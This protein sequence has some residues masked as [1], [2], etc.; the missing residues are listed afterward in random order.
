MS[1]AA[2]APEADVGKSSSARMGGA[3]RVSNPGD[4]HE[5]EA[6]RVADTVMRGGQ[7]PEWSLAAKGFDGIQRKPAESH[8]DPVAQVEHALAA[9]AEGRAAIAKVTAGAASGLTVTGA[10]AADVV[11]ALATGRKGTGGASIALDGIH[12]G[13]SVKVTRGGG[14]GGAEVALNYA[15]QTEGKQAAPEKKAAPKLLDKPEV[16][17]APHDGRGV[18]A[19]KQSG[20]REG[21]EKEELTVHRKAERAEA[22]YTGSAEVDSVLRSPGREMEP[23]TRREMESRIGFDFGRVR[24]HT[25]AR[26]GESAQGLSARAYTVGSDVVFA[27]GKYA[28]QTNEGRHLLAHELTHVVQQTSG[29]ERGRAAGLNVAKPAARIVQR[30][31]WSDVKDWVGDKIDSI[32]N[33]LLSH[34]KDIPGYD[35]FCTL[36]GRDLATGETVERTPEKLISEFLKFFGFDSLYEKLKSASEA[37]KLAFDWLMERVRARHL[38]LEDFEDLLKRAWDAVELTDLS[39]TWERLKAIFAEP[40]NNIKE[41]VKEIASKVLELIAEAVFNRFPAGRKIWQI[42]K[43]AAQAIG[44]IATSPRRFGET[45]LEA[46]K[47]GFQ[48]FDDHLGE[49]LKEGLLQFVFD[50]VGLPDLKA[51]KSFDLSSMFN[52]A[53][54]VLGLTYARRRKQ[55]VEKLE[56][57][58]GEVVV[59]YAEK[60]VEIVQQVRK[61]GFGAIWEMIKDKLASIP[62]TIFNAVKGWAIT[63][64]VKVGLAKIAALTNPVGEIIE[65]IEDIVETVKF[66]IEKASQLIDLFEAMVDMFSDLA[67]GN[68]ESAAV[69]VEGVIKK[70]IPLILRFLAGIF[71]FGDFGAKIKSVIT[72]VRETVDDAIGK[73]LDFIVDKITPIWNRVKES[74]MAR[75]ESVKQWWTKPKKFNYGDEE[76]QVSLEGDGDHPKIFVESNK[77]ALEHFLNDVKATKKERDPILKAAAKL[78]WKQGELEKPSGDEAGAGAYER[79]VV[80]LGKLKARVAPKS[81]IKANGPLDAAGG[82]TRAEAF[83]SAN[84]DLGSEPN[85]NDPAVWED[86]GA[87]LRKEKSYV[88]G[89]LLS[90]RLGG[91]G[92]WPNMMPITN[93][94][95]QRMNARVEAPLK[96]ATANT[97]RYYHYTVKAEYTA[98]TLP[99]L[100]DSP[101][102]KELIDRGKQ[103][104]KR[105]VSL[106]WITEPAEF[107]NGKWVAKPGPLLDENGKDMPTT[108]AAGDFTP[109]TLG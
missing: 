107:E 92:V 48:K 85:D 104:E 7:V 58:G 21:G 22:M 35:L 5:V 78:H 99:D 25:D 49:N 26:A 11:A 46:L 40:L 88:R 98:V 97:S 45:L 74:V 72:E 43:K 28:P 15:P 8:T 52:L 56:P 9:S 63:K 51:P 29:A 20:A 102:K 32:K 71:G 6:D 108:V 86:L 13:L 17:V 75:I 36:I 44:K 30:S 12:P 94:V 106:S 27:P 47:K 19:P 89:H 84:R 101:K 91:Q 73:V 66:F 67:D 103:A 33:W 60:A 38:T 109:P 57:L 41:L 83:L 1:R 93:K 3:V 59:E 54:E 96:R 14:A 105:L 65:V 16:K 81:E 53:L 50:E 95:N 80:L 34:L 2:F 69:A 62:G 64:I 82:G 37:L 10:A 39:G 31:W 79:L 87:P 70:S 100:S 24:L 77:T 42:L 18:T 4:S 55:L 23:A 76:H 68:S 61:G 90:M